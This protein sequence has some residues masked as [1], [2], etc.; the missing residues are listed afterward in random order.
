MDFNE[1]EA[2]LVWVFGTPR[3]GSTWLARDIL[4]KKE[5]KFQDESQIGQHLGVIRHD[6][7]TVWNIV[8]GVPNT[9]FPR[10][11]DKDRQD[12]FF[13]EK[14]V[15]SWKKPLRDLIISRL[16]AQHDLDSLDY[17]VMKSPNESYGSDIV[18]KCFPKS[19]LVFLIRDGR[20]VIDSRQ[21][22]FHNPGKDNQKK[23]H[24]LF[25][26]H[27]FAMLW[28]IMIET[29]QKAYQLHDEHLRL[30]LKYEDLRTKPFAEINKIYKFLGY[31]LS[32]EELEKIV[33]E[34]RFENVPEEKKGD[35]KNI[36]KASPGGYQETMNKNEIKLL[37]S[38]MGENLK[39][40]GYN[41]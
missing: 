37:N 34:T 16:T 29:T 8:N 32:N 39:K 24:T 33:E 10:I 35:D 21:G 23:E 28:N 2:K 9:K 12:L 27:Y 14:Y 26:L 13:S 11:I 1:V 6:P 5:I 4:K 41:V 3:S 15:T 30:M 17:L 25:R 22:K 7:S 38:L 40:F 18:M 19:K 36:R 31:E 20:D